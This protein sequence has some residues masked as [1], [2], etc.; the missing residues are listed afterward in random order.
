MELLIAIQRKLRSEIICFDAINSLSTPPEMYLEEALA[1]LLLSDAGA[2]K[3]V[4]GLE[5]RWNVFDLRQ[6]RNETF[7][8]LHNIT[9]AQAAFYDDLYKQK[10]VFV[11]R[12][13][14][15][16]D[17]MLSSLSLERNDYNQMKQH[18]YN[19]MRPVSYPLRK[20]RQQEWKA[21][22]LAL[23]TRADRY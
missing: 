15:M 4:C 19:S 6:Y 22:R 13:L 17:L 3:A 10:L 1:V 21:S 5:R 16:T 8:R 11:K 20:K 12:L 14:F 7:H 9:T 18:M 2:D 23:A